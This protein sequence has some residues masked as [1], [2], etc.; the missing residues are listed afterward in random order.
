MVNWVKP[1]LSVYFCV[2]QITK[3]YS[4]KHGLRLEKEIM[5]SSDLEIVY[6]NNQ[7]ELFVQG[8]CLIE[9]KIYRLDN[10]L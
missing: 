10:E 6:I 2:D 4:A 8:G 9:W 3:D 1:I 7:F 5:V